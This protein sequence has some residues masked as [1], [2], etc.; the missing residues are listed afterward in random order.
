MTGTVF[1][2]WKCGEPL[3]PKKNAIITTFQITYMG[4]CCGETFH[5]ALR[6]TIATMPSG[7]QA[8]Y[9]ERDGKWYFEK[10][11]LISDSVDEVKECYAKLVEKRYGATNL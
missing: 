4:I 6:D 5:E 11:Q 2:I 1:K 7:R 10:E 3:P 9:T 8:F